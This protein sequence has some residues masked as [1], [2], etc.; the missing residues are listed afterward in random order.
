M[1]KTVNATICDGKRYFAGGQWR[2]ITGMYSDTLHSVFQCDSIVTTNLVVKEPVVVSLGNDTVICHGDPI[3][4]S[5]HI[6]GDEYTWQDNS[7][8]SYFIVTQPGQYA[9][10]V[11]KQGCSGS[12]NITVT[13]CPPDASSIWIPNAFSPNGDGVNDI[14]KPACQNIVK[15]HMGIFDRWGT[16]IFTTS[17]SLDGW[18]GL[19]N[20]SYYPPGV[21]TYRIDFEGVEFP[22]VNQVRKG[23]ITLVR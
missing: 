6:D 2:R 7:H 8:E 13:E 17:D 23:T 9:V 16:M 4:L 5:P 10:T 20:G 11:T 3:T 1:H 21:Y 15:F 22:G 14:F 19:K 18:T 12:D